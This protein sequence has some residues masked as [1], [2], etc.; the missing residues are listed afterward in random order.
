M[1]QKYVPL[2]PLK[3]ASVQGNDRIGNNYNEVCLV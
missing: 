1:K 3:N 2:T